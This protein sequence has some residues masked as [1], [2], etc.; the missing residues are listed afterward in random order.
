[1]VV[2][3]V[4]VVV[5]AGFQVVELVLYAEVSRTLGLFILVCLKKE[6]KIYD[7]TYAYDC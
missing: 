5:V 2:V 4:V 3:V 6:K 7:W 1:V